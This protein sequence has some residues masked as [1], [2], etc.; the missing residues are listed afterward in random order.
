MR[1][2]DSFGGTKAGSSRCMPRDLRLVVNEVLLRMP[3]DRWVHGNAAVSLR[4][5]ATWASANAARR[6]RDQADVKRLR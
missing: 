6:Q 5:G 4:S 2:F 3:E 1:R